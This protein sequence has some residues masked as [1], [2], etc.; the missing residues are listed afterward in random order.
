MPH[1][2]NISIRRGIPSD[3]ADVQRL[4]RALFQYEH[5]HGYYSDNSYNL[6]WP[7]EEAGTKYFTDCLSGRPDRVVFIVEASGKA[8]AYLAASYAT[9]PFRS[10][11]PIGELDNMFVE[12]AYRH[13]GVGTQLVEAFKGW[14]RESQVARIRVGAF[15]HNSPALAFYR[16]LGFT[17]TELHLEQPVD[18]GASR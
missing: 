5:D 11:N 9:K 18:P 4:N 17:D 12:E 1:H 15:A 6:N 13:Q 3:L 14:A 8:V 10:Q 7:Y 2:S 16:R